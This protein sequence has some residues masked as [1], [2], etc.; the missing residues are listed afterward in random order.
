M[1][2]Y[3]VNALVSMG[4]CAYVHMRGFE[5]QSEVFPLLLSFFTLSL[6]LELKLILIELQGSA[7][8]TSSS[9]CLCGSRQKPPYQAFICG[10]WN[11][12]SGLVCLPIRYF[13][14]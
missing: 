3:V 9:Q 6:L 10:C 4:V 7:S 12:N 5:D 11:L 14:D 2:Y 8:L 13:I 1:L